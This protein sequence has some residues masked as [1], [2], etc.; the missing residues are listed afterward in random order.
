MARDRL[1]GFW[2]GSRQ[3]PSPVLVGQIDEEDPRSREVYA[4]QGGRERGDWVPVAEQLREQLPV[5]TDD[6]APF[7]R[8]SPGAALRRVLRRVAR[9]PGQALAL[10]AQLGIPAGTPQPLQAWLTQDPRRQDNADDAL[11]KVWRPTRGGF[12]EAL[13]SHPREAAGR[14]VDRR[15]GR[16][17]S[18]PT[19]QVV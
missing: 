2:Y 3:P 16:F 5:L 11:A 7:A 6:A 8:R 12:L 17:G 4:L 1:G 14:L 18:W 10:L 13:L 9:D 15:A 19:G